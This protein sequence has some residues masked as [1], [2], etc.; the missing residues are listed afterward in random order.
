MED[1]AKSSPTSA[2]SI[3]MDELI[4]ILERYVPVRKLKKKSRS[5]IDRKRNI[6]WRRLAKVKARIK[7]ASSIHKL[8]KLLQDK[9]DLEQQLVEDYSAVNSQEEDNAV[10]NM[11]TNPKSFFSFSK[12]RQ[13]T[14]S[15]IGPFIDQ[16]G[17][18]NPDPDFAAAEL[19]KQY[20]SVFVEPRSEWV[21]KDVN[22]F[23]QSD[24][25][26]GPCLM[27]IDFTEKDIEAACSELKASS[28]AG[29]DGVP[30][31]LLKTCRRELSKPLT[32]LW[33]SSLDHGV[34]PADLLLVLISPVHK[35]GSRGI[36]K[37]YR[38][39]ALTSH[40]VKVFERVIRRALVKHLEENNLLPEGQHGFRALRSTLT[41]LLSYWETILSELECGNCVTVLM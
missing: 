12:K 3:F 34:I 22:E 25:D 36:A 41:Q 29:A 17:K 14:R 13:K 1:A 9:A 38:P 24:L 26:S 2:L 10:L 23:F 33:R 11:K 40:I 37:N 39:V 8:T 7:T 6:C 30:A 5:R 20:S 15:K 31:C 4:P 18:P 19:G 32:I 16:S 28:A 21:I 35:G 27:D